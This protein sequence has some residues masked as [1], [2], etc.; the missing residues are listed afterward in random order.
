MKN[1]FTRADYFA[2]KHHYLFFAFLLNILRIISFFVIFLT[3]VIVTI[4]TIVDN[5]GSMFIKIYHFFE[6]I[7]PILIPI[8][9]IFWILVKIIVVFFKRKLYG[10]KIKLEIVDEI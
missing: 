9:I 5:K 7:S 10:I 6:K 3:I 8:L 2:I 1:N 4:N